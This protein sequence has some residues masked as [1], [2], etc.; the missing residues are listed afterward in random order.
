M[1]VVY[2]LNKEANGS[3]FEALFRQ[4]VISLEHIDKLSDETLIRT[5]RTCGLIDRHDRE[6]CYDARAL[7]KQL[8]LAATQHDFDMPVAKRIYL[9]L[10]TSEQ[11][12]RR[13]CMFQRFKAQW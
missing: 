12:A 9:R 3:H 2:T 6:L 11:L 1:S 7:V 13:E 10:F 4:C 5:A 8:K